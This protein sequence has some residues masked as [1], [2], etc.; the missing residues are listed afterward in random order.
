MFV[1]RMLSEDVCCAVRSA[2][3][4]AHML[5]GVSHCNQTCTCFVHRDENEDFSNGPKAWV[6]PVRLTSIF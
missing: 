2:C 4:G 6:W 5:Q 1:Q 3:A